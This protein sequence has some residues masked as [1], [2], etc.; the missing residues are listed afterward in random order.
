[1]STNQFENLSKWL[2]ST[3]VTNV[4]PSP[5]VSESKVP[6]GDDF[7]MTTVYLN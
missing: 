2:F 1:V 3:K 6:N 7:S 4:I 5:F